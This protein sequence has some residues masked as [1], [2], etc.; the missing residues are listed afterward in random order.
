MLNLDHFIADLTANR[1]KNDELSPAAR[2]VICTLVAVG[3]SQRSIASQFGIS[4]STVRTTLEHW[5]SHKTFD[6]K[7]RSG[8]K[9]VL[10]R[11]EKRYIL[12]LVK[13]NRTL[14][15]KALINAVGKKISYSTV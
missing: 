14:A 7:K 12:L 10:S 3:R 2:A 5:K 8:R 4:N 11:A 9:Q 1:G 15:K 13:K 6:S